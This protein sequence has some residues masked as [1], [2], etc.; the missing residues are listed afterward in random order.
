[1]RAIGV[2]ARSGK[3]PFLGH[4][5]VILSLQGSKPGPFDKGT[6]PWVR[7]PTSRPNHLLAAPSKHRPVAVS[8]PTCEF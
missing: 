4:W 2:P 3:G 8:E 5:L 1:M 7:A 6:N